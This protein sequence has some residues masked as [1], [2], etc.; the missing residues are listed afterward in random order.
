MGEDHQLARGDEREEGPH[1]CCLLSVH[2]SDSGLLYTRLQAE[3]ETQGIM[4]PVSFT[5]NVGT[6]TQGLTCA[7]Q[8]LYR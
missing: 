8:T 7:R 1:R 4:A 6:Q 2:A 5:C 3:P